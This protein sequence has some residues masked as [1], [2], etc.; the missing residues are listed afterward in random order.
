MYVWHTIYQ[1]LYSKKHP[2]LNA[3]WKSVIFKHLLYSKELKPIHYIR[4]EQQDPIVMAL[5]VIILSYLSINSTW[6]VLR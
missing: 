5:D 6:S 1:L 4:R 2:Y 3:S